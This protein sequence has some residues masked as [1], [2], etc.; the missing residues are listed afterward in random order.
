MNQRFLNSLFFFAFLFFS[1]SFS[2]LKKKSLFDFNIF[3]KPRTGGLLTKSNARKILDQTK[4]F[5]NVG[6]CGDFW[7]F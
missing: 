4:P 3:Y 7:Q 2:F 6:N 5:D 1:F